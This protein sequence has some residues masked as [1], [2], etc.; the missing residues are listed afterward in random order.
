MLEAS[1]NTETKTDTDA[2]KSELTKYGNISDKGDRE[3][4]RASY[5]KDA[6]TYFAAWQK[7]ESGR[8]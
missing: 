6:K 5:E 7:S 2:L 8:G 3:K 4:M 1:G